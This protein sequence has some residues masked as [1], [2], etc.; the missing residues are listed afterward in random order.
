MNLNTRIRSIQVSTSSTDLYR[1]GIMQAP[2]SGNSAEIFH[3]VKANQVDLYRQ[4]LFEYRSNQGAYPKNGPSATFLGQETT[5]LIS[6]VFLNI[7]VFDPKPV[8]IVEWLFEAG[9]R[10]WIVRVSQEKQIVDYIAGESRSDTPGLDN[11]IEGISLESDNVDV[12]STSSEDRD[13]P[14]SPRAAPR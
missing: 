13:R 3:D 14:A 5:S 9:E 2:G 4:T 10:L 8:Q 1:A 7:D 12:P 11:L 6:T